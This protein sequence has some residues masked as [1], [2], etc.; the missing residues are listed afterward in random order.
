MAT[1]VSVNV[2]EFRQK[3]PA[4]AD[5]TKYSDE[6][7]QADLDT[8]QLYISP[9][10]NRFVTQAQLK[11]M[12][13]LLTAHL[14][15]TNTQFAKGNSNAGAIATSAHIDGVSVTVAIP[16]SKSA[17]DYFLN[18]TGYGRQLLALLTLLSK[19]GFYVGGQKENVFR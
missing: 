18:S 14:A 4:F 7:L 2:S 6:T 10:I 8:A 11:Q 9:K 3:F 15:E 17:L 19:V 5:T 13:Y 12:I 16:E 1:T